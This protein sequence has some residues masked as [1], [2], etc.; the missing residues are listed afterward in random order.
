MV[1]VYIDGERGR[2]KARKSGGEK[3]NMAGLEFCPARSCVE[4]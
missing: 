2:D 3:C 1:S 4:G